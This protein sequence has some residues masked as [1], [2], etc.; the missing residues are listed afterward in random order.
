M[1][2][3]NEVPSAHM[4]K[5]SFLFSL[6]SWAKLYIVDTLQEVGSMAA[7]IDPS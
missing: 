1:V 4:M 5:S 7:V 2:F 6:W 3:E